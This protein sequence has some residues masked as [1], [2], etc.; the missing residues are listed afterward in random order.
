MPTQHPNGWSDRIRLLHEQSGGFLDMIVIVPS[1]M[2]EL[3][4]LAAA[5]DAEAV[6]AV[7]AVSELIG[8]VEAATRARPETCSACDRPLRAKTYKIVIAYAG[9]IDREGDVVTFGL[10]GTLRC[11]ATSADV[12]RQSARVLR[13]FWPAAK[14]IPA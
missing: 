10:C 11:S 3:C 13:R 7:G 5:G 2:R 9:S 14:A 1:D 4:D 12:Q 6:R 8:F